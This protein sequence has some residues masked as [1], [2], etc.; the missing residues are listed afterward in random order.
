MSRHDRNFEG[1]TVEDAGKSYVFP[2]LLC[3]VLYII[4][5][6]LYYSVL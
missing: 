6:V 1:L 4:V 3:L 2:L 5:T